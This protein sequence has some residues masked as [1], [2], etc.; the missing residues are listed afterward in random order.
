[1]GVLAQP[2]KPSANAAASVHIVKRG[3]KDVVMVN[4]SIKNGA[5]D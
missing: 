2:D 5:L 1:M 4:P 3:E